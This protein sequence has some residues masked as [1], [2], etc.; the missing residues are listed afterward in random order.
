VAATS[1]AGQAT[2]TKT[3]QVEPTATKWCIGNSPVAAADALLNATSLLLAA[4]A[5]GGT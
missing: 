3:I 1:S 2:A 4:P 5:P